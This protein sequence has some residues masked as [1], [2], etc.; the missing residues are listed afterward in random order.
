MSN[1]RTSRAGSV[2]AFVLSGLFIIAAVWIFSNRQFILDQLSVWSY[3]PSSEVAAIQQRINMT[4]EGQFT[5]YATH[6][7]VETQASFNQA[8]PRQEAGSPILGCYTPDDRIYIYNLS[9]KQLDGMKEVTAAHEMLHAVWYRT[10]EA[11]KEKLTTELK[12]AYEKIDDASLQ[13]RMDYYERTEPGEFINELHSILGTE[14]AS[15]GEPLES[16]YAQFFDRGAVLKLHDQ[17]S[18]LYE[19]LYERADTLYA[20]MQS[21]ATVINRQSNEYTSA[22]AQLSRDI[23]SF[24]RRADGGAFSTQGEFNSERATLI[25]RS[26]ALERQRLQINRNIETYNGYYAEYQEIA[27]QIEV[28][29]DSIDSFKQVDQ[30]PTV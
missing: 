19:K 3:T 29:N 28:L 11:E 13:K 25:Q 6:P 17:Y 1:T 7:E 26:N 10:S 20:Q 22:A 21:L 30:P 9:N 16:Y 23:D 14:V 18:G 24:N 15:L 12:V 4:D 27:K 2:V 5:F 8:C